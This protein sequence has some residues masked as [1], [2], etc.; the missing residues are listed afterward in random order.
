MD[1]ESTYFTTNEIFGNR[2]YG[3][4]AAK[5]SYSDSEITSLVN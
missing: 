4:I 1:D 5:E 2:F 3:H